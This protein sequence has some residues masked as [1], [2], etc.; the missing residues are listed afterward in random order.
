MH[1]PVGVQKLR[2]VGGSYV[3]T[4]PIEHVRDLGLSENDLLDVSIEPLEVRRRIRPEVRAAF[5]AVRP[6]IQPGLDYLKDR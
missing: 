1:H 3:V 4:I 5:E 2:K 6:A